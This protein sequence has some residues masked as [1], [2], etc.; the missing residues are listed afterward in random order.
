M[1]GARQPAGARTEAPT[2]HRQ[3]VSPER[4]LID[5]AEAIARAALDAGCDFFAGYPI[6]PASGI[7][8]HMLAELPARGGVGIQGED[9]IAS[10]GFCIG[11][12]LAGARPMTATS[13]PGLALYAENLGVAVMVEVPLVVVVV[14]RLGPA[15]GAATAGAQGDVQTI[16]WIASGG[17]PILALS[18]TDLADS[19]HLTRRAFDLAERFR[20]PVFLATDKEVVMTTDTVAAAAMV[21]PP[22]DWPPV[23]TD[24][25]VPALAP[26]GRTENGG[27]PRRYNASSHDERG[28]ITKEPGV[29]ERLNR[30]LADKIADHRSELE[31]VRLDGE[32]GARTLV[33]GY[34]V[35]ARSVD[36]AVRSLRAE[37]RKVAA[38]TILSLW[39]VPERALR[40][41][42]DG[43]ERVVVAELNL[44]QY[45]REVERVVG[46]RVE[47]VGVHRVDGQLITPRQ[48][49]AEAL[50]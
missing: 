30:H 36:D 3:A 39:P 6:T 21:G 29:L 16:R 25:V 34:G 14:Q 49:A 19:Y 50:A 20:V 28:Y 44:G 46:D 13:G 23:S 35:T 32:P 9:E 48:I 47:V 31:L 8:S 5:G 2:T 10:I 1:S 33:V 24:R 41:A 12:A 22:S 15:T 43:V 42:V 38:L 4:E 27:G 7:L 37:G 18:P 45:R 26:Y 40:D 17:Y 11:A